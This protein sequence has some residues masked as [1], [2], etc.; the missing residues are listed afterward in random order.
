MTLP[1]IDLASLKPNSTFQNLYH[2]EGGDGSKLT[3]GLRKYNMHF[4]VEHLK[5]IAQNKRAAAVALKI[6]KFVLDLIIYPILGTVALLGVVINAV[7]VKLNNCS[8]QSNLKKAVQ[9]ATAMTY[10]MAKFDNGNPQDVNTFTGAID[11]PQAQKQLLSVIKQT[12]KKATRN[13]LFVAKFQTSHPIN[14]VTNMAQTYMLQVDISTHVVANQDV[15]N[16]SI[17]VMETLT[18]QMP[19]ALGS[20]QALFAT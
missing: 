8:R 17:K 20:L 13:G 1:Q 4:K 19:N 18:K 7:H 12:V 9:S 11:T 3:A 5:L 2:V 14:P 6:V 16:K 10:I 15:I